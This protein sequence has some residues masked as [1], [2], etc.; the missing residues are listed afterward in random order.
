MGICQETQNVTLG[1]AR[2]TSFGEH[3]KHDAQGDD[4][5]ST[6]NFVRPYLAD[7]LPMLRMFVFGRFMCSG[8][9]GGRDAQAD[10]F[11]DFLFRAGL[12]EIARITYPRCA[13]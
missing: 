11:A 3:D 6:E 13:S 5:M 7:M 8:S 12:S 9:V 4:T 10:V 2:G 1:F